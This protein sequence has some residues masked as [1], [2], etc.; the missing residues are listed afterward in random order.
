MNT[1]MPFL[2]KKKMFNMQQS[3]VGGIA[4][5]QPMKLEF[6][7]V[8]ELAH[9]CVREWGGFMIH[10]MFSTLPHIFSCILFSSQVH[11]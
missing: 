1:R 10:V 11:M 4:W 5:E 3:Y 2:W 6:L 8:V 9:F 7:R